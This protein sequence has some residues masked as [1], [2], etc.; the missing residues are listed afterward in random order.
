[1]EGEVGFEAG[2]VF[3]LLLGVV[4][5]V[6]DQTGVFVIE[7]LY[8]LGCLI[9]LHTINPNPVLQVKIKAFESQILS[10][11]LVLIGLQGVQFVLEDA[12]VLFRVFKL[13]FVGLSKAGLL[14]V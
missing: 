7:K 12:A 3:G 13:A 8:F 1:M 6:L 2:Q 14:G 4:V 11:G 10:H 9:N 5:Q